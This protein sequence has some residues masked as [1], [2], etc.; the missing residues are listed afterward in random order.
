MTI[1]TLTNGFEI[2]YMFMILLTL[3]GLI[4]YEIKFNMKD[5]INSFIRFTNKMTITF[6]FITFIFMFI[7]E[8]IG[9][10]NVLLFFQE[11][12]TG[13]IYYMFF[14]Y[15]V[16]FGLKMIHEGKDFFKTADLFG[17]SYIQGKLKGGDKK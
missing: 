12:M 11:V 13:L 17:Y 14:S 7:F 16:F 6:I 2:F 4:K 5:L 3:W 10:S 9:D 8:L 1:I 15:F